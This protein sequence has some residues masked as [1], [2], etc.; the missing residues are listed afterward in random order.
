MAPIKKLL[1]CAQN[2]PCGRSAQVRAQ[3]AAG[4]GA[5][6]DGCLRPLAEPAERGMVMEDEHDDQLYN[7][8]GPRG[9]M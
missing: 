8:R 3:L 1:R 6:A 2:V 9:D 7:V 5:D 4:A